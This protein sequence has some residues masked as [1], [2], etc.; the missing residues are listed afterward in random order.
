MCDFEFSNE[1]WLQ[2][3]GE[4]GATF[5]RR[6]E[7]CYRFVKADEEVF[8]NDREKDNATCSKCGRTKMIF[9]GYN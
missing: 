5:V 4:D 8:V 7:K 3:E 9:I 1:P 2:Y 6:C